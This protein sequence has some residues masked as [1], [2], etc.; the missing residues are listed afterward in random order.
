VPGVSVSGGSKG[1]VT[2]PSFGENERTGSSGP[3]RSSLSKSQGGPDITIVASARA[4]GALNLY[5]ALQG[6]KV[7]TIYIDTNIGTVVLEYADPSS[8]GHPYGVELTAPEPLRAELPPRLS[9]SRLVIACVLDRNGQLRNARVLQ[10][11]TASMTARVLAALQTWKFRPAQRGS[12][13]VEVNAIVGF[14]IDT[15]DKY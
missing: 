15:N 6:D 1:V 9:R 10:A 5:G 11:G 2:L 3:E 7:Y 13:P 12:A 14:N 4:G 8:A